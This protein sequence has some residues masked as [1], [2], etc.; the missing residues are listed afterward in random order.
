[1]GELFYVNSELVMKKSSIPTK[2]PTLAS[3]LDL[4]AEPVEKFG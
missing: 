1:V 3:I 2:S 4:R